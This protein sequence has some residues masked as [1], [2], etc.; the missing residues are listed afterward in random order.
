MVY[1]LKLFSG[2]L[3]DVKQSAHHRNCDAVNASAGNSTCSY[4]FY[5]GSRPYLEASGYESMELF[6]KRSV[7][8][9]DNHTINDLS[10][11]RKDGNMMLDS[12]LDG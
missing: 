8:L 5:D 10:R 1:I 11:V 9:I 2:Y 3:T 12:C 4:D 6:A 7:K